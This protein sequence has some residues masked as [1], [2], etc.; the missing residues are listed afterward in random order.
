MSQ[1]MRNFV[2]TMYAQEEIKPYAASGEK[3]Q[4]VEQMFDGI[5]HSYDRLNHV[6]SLGIDR[7]W[8]RKTIKA[9]L[10]YGPQ[11]ILDIATGTGDFA[12]LAAELLKPES[13]VG[14]DLSEGMMQIGRQKVEKAGLSKTISFQKE[15]CMAL[16]FADGSFDA[17]IAA[18]GVRNFADLDRGL[19]EM[20][21]VLRPGGH[22]AILELAAPKR[23]PMKQLFWLY[24]H[25]VMPLVGK[26][27]SKDKRAYSYLPQTMEAVPQGKNMQAIMEK[28]GFEDVRFKAFTF[29]LSTMYIGKRND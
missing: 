5:A 18:Y 10:P 23:F 2:R 9:L 14:A 1:I 21:R 19:R 27:V 25:A 6:L 7:R 16:S 17:V 24:S 13:I 4:Q 29:G 8:R 12:L 3:G 15:D 20:L 11:R 22:V 28:A 26:L